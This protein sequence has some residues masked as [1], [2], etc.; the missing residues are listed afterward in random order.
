[1]ATQNLSGYDKEHLPDAQSM[2]IGIV[3]SE[4]NDHITSN[5]LKGCVEALTDCGVQSRNIL[6][7]H[8]PGSFELATGA[9]ML[10]DN[11][12]PE[13][14]ICLGCVIRGETAH[15]DFVCQACAS[16]IQQLALKTGK[17]VIFGVLTDDSEEQSIARSGGSKGNKGI[18]AA[19]TAI[20]M[21][22]LKR[23][24]ESNSW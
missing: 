18:E 14:V 4:W 13:A 1:M 8:V 17:P 9:Q 20:K 2:R 16:G 7:A 10:F 6:V 3:V 12:R 22:G 19:I 5:L 21:I 23:E 24:L 11:H 15:F